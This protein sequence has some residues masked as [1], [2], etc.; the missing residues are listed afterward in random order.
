MPGKICNMKTLLKPITGMFG[1]KDGDTSENTEALKKEVTM[2]D[3]ELARQ[4]CKLFAAV[5]EVKTKLKKLEGAKGQITE[6]RFNSLHGQYAGFLDKNT[7]VLKQIRETINK[8][9]TSY[10]QE[11]KSAAHR[12]AEIKKIVSQESKLLEAG[13]ISKEDYLEKIKDLK[14]EEKECGEK[15]KLSQK[16]IAFLKDAKDNIYV[17]PDPEM[18]QVSSSSDGKGSDSDGEEKRSGSYEKKAY[19]KEKKILGRDVDIKFEPGVKLDVVIKDIAIPVTA[20]FVGTE[21][22]EYILINHPSPYNTVKGKLVPG[23]R[24]ELQCLVKGRRFIFASKIIESLVKPIRAVVLKYPKE[25]V[26]KDL[27]SNIRV[28]C[29]IPSSLVFKGKSKDSFIID[30]SPSGCRIETSYHPSEK[31]YIAR[32]GDNI[33]IECCFPGDPEKYTIPG[34]I[35]NVKKKQLAVSYGIQLIDLSGEIR[36]AIVTYASEGVQ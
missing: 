12:F 6:E 33:N 17:E 22:Y 21:K 16:Q 36:K 13:V 2:D 23:N 34:I 30:L 19:K 25:L 14:P 8:R 18:E 10:V 15:Y 1:K 35:R 5:T 11:K 9:V 29:R 27:R 20:V 32:S 3:N 24:L 4:H 7:P 31:N 28:T 26:I